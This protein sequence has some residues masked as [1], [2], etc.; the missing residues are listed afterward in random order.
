[1]PIRRVTAH[2]KVEPD[3]NRVAVE[4]G[5]MVFCAEWPDNNGK[6]HGLILPDERKADVRVPKRHARRHRSDQGKSPGGK[7]GV[8]RHQ[9]LVKAEHELLLI[10][11]YAWAHRGTGEMDVWLA[12]NDEAI[13]AMLKK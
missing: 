12:R 11:Y 2:E 13:K 8:K 9:S 6:T 7:S 5:P 4:R 1:M 3:R 10:P